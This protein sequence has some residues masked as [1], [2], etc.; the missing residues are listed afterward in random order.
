[1]FCKVGTCSQHGNLQKTCHL[2]PI[3][4]YTI[5][6]TTFAAANL[7][8]LVNQRFPVSLPALKHPI[9]LLYY[10]AR[11]LYPKLDTLKAE[12]L[13]HKPY[14]VCI[15]E[16]WLSD[17]ISNHELH[18]PG[19]C[20]VRLDRSRHGRGVLMYIRDLFTYNTI[21]VGNQTFE[22]IIVSF[23]FLSCKF[24]VCLLYRPPSSQGVLDCLFSTLS[25]LYVSLFSNF[26]IVGDFNI[27]FSNPSH[28]LYSQLFTITSSFSL[29]QAVKDF[30]HFNFNGNH[31]IIDLVFISSPSHL[32][33]CY[34][35]PPSLP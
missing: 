11:S 28:P 6:L 18:I 19:Y 33:S 30:T 14:I 35:I 10:N 23:G 16:S 12:C 13:L 1:M 29:Y 4:T 17:Y 5:R 8:I 34:T 3:E 24:C 26:F 20:V 32:N 31:S 21:F 7:H 2:M 27:D 22:C 9:T 25:N 15:T